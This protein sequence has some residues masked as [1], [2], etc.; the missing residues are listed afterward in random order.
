VS[1]FFRVASI[2][3]SFPMFLNVLR[4]SESLDVWK[5][6]GREIGVNYSRD[7]AE[8]IQRNPHLCKLII[9]GAHIGPEGARVVARALEGHPSLTWVDMGHNNIG[10]SGAE[11]LAAA[12]GNNS[13]LTYLKLNDNGI[14]DSGIA[15]LA[16]ALEK[17]TTVV[18]LDVG[19]VRDTAA[20]GSLKLRVGR[21]RARKADV[22]RSDGSDAGPASEAFALQTEVQKLNNRIRKVT[23]E[24]EQLAQRFLELQWENESLRYDQLYLQKLCEDLESAHEWANRTEHRR[25][26]TQVNEVLHERI[27]QL[28]WQISVLKNGNLRDTDD[29]CPHCGCGIS[30]GSSAVSSVSE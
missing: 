9:F 28:E 11:A 13:I 14:T 12:L 6:A 10:D 8:A 5:L 25:R 21:N 15:A 16:K 26:S 3:R 29:C 20:S 7:L 4:D 27:H 23:A 1:I 30:T 18:C 17:N 2:Y 22:Q 19:E 24:K